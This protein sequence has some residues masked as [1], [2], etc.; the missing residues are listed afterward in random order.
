MFCQREKRCELSF[1]SNV[2]S[3]LEEREQKNGA[4]DAVHS[5]HSTLSREHKIA[6]EKEIAASIRFP[7]SQW[8]ISR[9]YIAHA[10]EHMEFSMLWQKLHQAQIFEK[11]VPKRRHTSITLCPT[12]LRKF[13]YNENEMV[14]LP[15]LVCINK[16]V[17]NHREDAVRS[18]LAI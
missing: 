3:S 10:R 5:N 18:V 15:A 17:H 13:F 8:F 6:Q 12:L 1:Y 11:N 14:T 16:F 9:N 7:T 2:I 4:I